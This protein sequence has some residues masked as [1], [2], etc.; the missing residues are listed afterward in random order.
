MFEEH[1]TTILQ[2]FKDR[3]LLTAE[4]CQEI[5]EEKDR[6]GKSAADLV[7]DFGILDRDR[8]LQTVADY[9]GMEYVNIDVAEEEFPED[10]IKLIPGA[11]ARL[12][13]IV[14]LAVTGNLLKL[15]IRD[16]F[17]SN[18]AQEISFILNK[19]VEVLVADPEKI[20]NFVSSHYKETRKDDDLQRIATFH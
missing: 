5:S 18:A 13:G 8:V 2:I 9:L 20:D 12:H 14:P 10:I 16:P 19:D 6:T 17:N 4:Q 3:D 11:S 15:A 7:I 1:S